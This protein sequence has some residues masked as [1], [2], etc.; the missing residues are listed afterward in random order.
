MLKNIRILMFVSLGLIYG[1]AMDDKLSYIYDVE[2]NICDII[3]NYNG[4][5]SIDDLN[6]PAF[7][8]KFP[9]RPKE[10]VFVT[11][12]ERMYVFMETLNDCL[13][14]QKHF[15]EEMEK[16]LNDGNNVDYDILKE[17]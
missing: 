14:Y 8:G 4:K 15:L 12:D 7:V 6:N 5:I 3:E 13:D 9:Q 1:N 11:Q 17:K 16:Q 10:I 2:T